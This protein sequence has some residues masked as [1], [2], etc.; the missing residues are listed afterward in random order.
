MLKRD[1]VW[2]V[3]SGGIGWM[4]LTVVTRAASSPQFDP[5]PTYAVGGRPQAV[6]VAESVGS[7]A[8]AGHTAGPG[9]RPL[10]AGRRV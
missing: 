5:C 4:A 3:V 9:Q 1:W 2:L 8:Q 6:A 10:R 7:C